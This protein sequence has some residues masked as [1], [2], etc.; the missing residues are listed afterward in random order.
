M[1]TAYLS[2]CPPRSSTAQG[3]VFLDLRESR[4]MNEDQASEK[5]REDIATQPCILKPCRVVLPDT[6]PTV[7]IA[8]G[9]DVLR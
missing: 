2:D 8:M 9:P 1:S 4:A 3:Q 7:P 5:S 6:T